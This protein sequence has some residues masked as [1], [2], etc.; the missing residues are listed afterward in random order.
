VITIDP[1]STIDLVGR[2]LSLAPGAKVTA[3]GTLTLAAGDLTIQEGAKLTVDTLDATVLGDAD[4]T[5]ACSIAGQLRSTGLP[6]SIGL[7]CQ[8]G[9]TVSGKVLTAG[10]SIAFGRVLGE[11]VNLDQNLSISGTINTKGSGS[12]GG[13]INAIVDGGIDVTGKLFVK[14]A[15]P[16]AYPGPIDLTANFGNLT[17][18]GKINAGGRDC[19]G[20]FC[21][22]SMVSASGT[23]TV[24]DGA[25][26]NAKVKTDG[27]QIKLE[28]DGDLTLGDKVKITASSSTRGG[29]IGLNSPSGSSAS[30]AELSVKATPR[31]GEGGRIG[32]CATGAVYMKADY[33]KKFALDARGGAGGTGGSIVMVA[34]DIIQMGFGLGF[35][36]GKVWAGLDP[37]GLVELCGESLSLVA[38]NSIDFRPECDLGTCRNQQSDT[39]NC[40]GPS[41]GPFDLDSVCD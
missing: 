6:G 14:G 9:H 13:G 4:T 7:D 10:A 2:S 40:S 1:N 19:T 25:Q 17:F 41:V 27:V 12:E 15:G 5:G 28:S 30:D 38:V 20:Q 21:F 24:V 36:G 33:P 32:V 18:S 22:I 11:P 8:G 3:T 37:E 26:I 23:L 16:T 35:G 39:A 29:E 34:D 31:G